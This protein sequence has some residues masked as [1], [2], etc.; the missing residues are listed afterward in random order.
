MAVGRYCAGL[1]AIVGLAGLLAGCGGSGNK[2]ATVSV[3]QREKALQAKLRA[4]LPLRAQLLKTNELAGFHPAG[5]RRPF[6]YDAA[7]WL[8][9]LEIPQRERTREAQR[10][11]RLG[12][13][14]GIEERLRP[15]KRSTNEE[16]TSLIE[17]FPSNSAAKAELA[18]QVQV[19][20][21]NGASE[22]PVSAI[23]GARGFSE[24]GN[25][26]V[27]FAEGRN[28]YLVGLAFPPGSSG[29]PGRGDVIAAAK[30]QFTRLHQT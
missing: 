2:T 16:G 15:I 27:A 8:E 20:K 13:Q 25:I 24:T 19:A 7:S 6:G 30:R 10:L 23:P 1:L 21:G 12:F 9:A 14:G 26:N 22:F 17:K 4:L 11:N 18:A 5:A 28:Y 3:Q 29:A